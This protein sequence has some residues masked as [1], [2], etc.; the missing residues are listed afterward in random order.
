M[1]NSYDGKEFAVRKCENTFAV[2]DSVGMCRFD[3][4][5]FNS[6]TLPDSG[7]FAEQVSTLTGQS[8]SRGR[9]WTRSAATSPASSACSISASACAAKDDTLPPRWFEEENTFGPFKGEKIDR[10]QFER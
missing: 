4:K 10:Q 8:L 7:D 1:P 2:G 9:T 5:L 3:T 6:P